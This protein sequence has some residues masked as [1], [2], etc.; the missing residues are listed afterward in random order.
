MNFVSLAVIHDRDIHALTR[1]PKWWEIGALVRAANRRRVAAYREAKIQD[2]HKVMAENIRRLRPGV[3][4]VLVKVS[5]PERVDERGING[6][7]VYL[8]AEV[9]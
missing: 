9:P 5:A 8:T 7:V 4:G 1:T 6:E 2:A 3:D